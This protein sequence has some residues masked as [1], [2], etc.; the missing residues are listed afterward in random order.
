LNLH[1]LVQTIKLDENERPERYTKNNVDLGKNYFK[2]RYIQ[3]K[4][5]QAIQQYEKSIEKKSSIFEQENSLTNEPS[6]RNYPVDKLTIKFNSLFLKQLEKGIFSFN[7][8]KYEDS[9]N[10]FID[11]SIVKNIE[12]FGELFLVVQ[13]FDKYVVG[14]FLSKEKQPNKEFA[15]LK[16]F[17]KKFCF[18]N[19]KFLEAFRF[20]LSR[21]NLPKDSSLILNIIDPFSEVYYK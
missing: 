21:I 19:M 4:L 11:N 1:Y 7:L 18:K 8:K 2:N 20:L 15:V 17:M 16:S 12:E 5:Q 10:Y 14:D 3:E 13:G 6:N 9:F